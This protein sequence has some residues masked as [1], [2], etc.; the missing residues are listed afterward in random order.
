VIFPLLVRQKMNMVFL[1]QLH[2]SKIEKSESQKDMKE[3]K[4][5]ELLAEGI[6]DLFTKGVGTVHQED[7]R[8]VER[9]CTERC[10]R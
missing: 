3:I 4:K 9:V 1:R 2:R 5:F 10:Q 8:V 6:K 7:T